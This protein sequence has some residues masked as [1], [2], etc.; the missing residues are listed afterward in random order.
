MQNGEEKRGSEIEIGLVS[1]S[2]ARRS[3][4][5][6]HDSAV[7]VGCEILEE[8]VGWALCQGMEAD[9]RVA[10][11][12][13][14]R[15]NHDIQYCGSQTAIRSSQDSLPAREPEEEA[16]IRDVVRIEMFKFSSFI[17]DV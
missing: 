5:Q 12:V 10:I 4:A 7:V 1:N 11:R 6:E 3:P 16:Q 9:T 2:V 17:P 15:Q 14:N 8:Q 13:D